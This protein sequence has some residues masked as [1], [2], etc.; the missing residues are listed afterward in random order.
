MST[1]SPTKGDASFVRHQRS[2]SSHS[3]TC[4]HT[5]ATL[6]WQTNQRLLNSVA[7]DYNTGPSSVFNHIQYSLLT[8]DL[9][10]STTSRHQS[11]G[12]IEQGTISAEFQQQRY[13][14]F[15]C[16]TYW[17]LTKHG[18]W[19]TVH[20]PRRSTSSMMIPFSTCFTFIGHFF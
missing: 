6:Q 14:S 7:Q 2:S 4:S 5:A 16:Y 8:M 17:L 15:S 19:A 20:V 3:R 12:R 11:T 10:I 9:C 13:A 1:V 18:P